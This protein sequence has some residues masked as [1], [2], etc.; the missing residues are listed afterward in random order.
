MLPA[1]ETRTILDTGM[2]QVQLASED[3]QSRSLL[4][5]QLIEEGVDVEAHQTIQD[6]VKGLASASNPPALLV[7]DISFSD[8]PA[9]DVELLSTLSTKI[10]IWVIASRAFIVQK[11]LRGRGFETTLLRPVDVGELVEQIKRRVGRK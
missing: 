11:G 8:N 3:W 9:S 1:R 7:A 4:R 2:A 10:S 5:A 6:A